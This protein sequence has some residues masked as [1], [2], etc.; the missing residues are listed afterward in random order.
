[1]DAGIF[2]KSFCGDLRLDNREYLFQN[3][4]LEWA[5]LNTKS[6]P[7]RN[8]NNAYFIFI[9]EILLQ[10]TDARKV[11]KIYT[12]FFEKFPTPA[13]LG[14][15]KIGDIEIAIRNIGLLNRASRLKK[16]GER[17]IHEFGGNI[18]SNKED[19]LIFYGIGNYISNS[20][21]CFAF[22]KKVPIVDTNVV[23][24]YERVFL[25][26][27]SKSRPSTDDKIW[28]FAERMLPDENYVNFNYALL[29]FGSEICRAKNPACQ[30]CP[31]KTI[32]YYCIQNSSQFPDIRYI[33]NLNSASRGL[34]RQMI[35]PKLK[36]GDFS[37]DKLHSIQKA[38]LGTPWKLSG[39]NANY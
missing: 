20:V 21:L 10:R 8:T 26:K 34:L 16:I 15:A 39:I 13:H 18:P 25:L 14:G 5:R 29:D 31:I 7:W 11:A 19:L 27:S 12:E 36:D 6:Y 9:S 38:I 37:F 17:L 32:C 24:I 35:V 23:R 3:Y 4:I 30:K 22:K 1:V 2:M 28:F 33:T